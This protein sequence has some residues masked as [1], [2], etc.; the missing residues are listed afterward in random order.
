MKMVLQGWGKQTI[1][2][3]LDRIERF[4]ISSNLVN[5]KNLSLLIKCYHVISGG[6]ISE[7]FSGQIYGKKYYQND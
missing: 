4:M 3:V 7:P 5:L 2:Y 6:A 1:Q